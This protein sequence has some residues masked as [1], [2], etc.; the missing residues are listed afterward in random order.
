MVNLFFTVGS[1]IMMDLY[2]IT[3]GDIGDHWLVIQESRLGGLTTEI[4]PK[5]LK[6]AKTTN[7]QIRMI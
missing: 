2:L 4:Y 7:K 5:V 3:C 6:Q 1:E